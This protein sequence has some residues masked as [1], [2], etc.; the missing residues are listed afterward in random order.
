MN[1]ALILAILLSSTVAAGA[2]TS[3]GNTATIDPAK[4]QT[5]TTRVQK[6]FA[7]LIAELKKD[8]NE[9][10]V[11]VE[12]SSALNA[13]ASPGKKIVVNSALIDYL[14]DTALAFV[15]AH[16]LGHLERH[17][18]AK[19]IIEQSLVS[20]IKQKFF[21]TSGLYNGA[22]Y[23]GNLGFS[24]SQEK[25]ADLFAVKLIDKLYCDKPGKIDFFKQPEFRLEVKF[26]DYTHSLISKVGT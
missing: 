22:A 21:P 4:L 23:L 26:L 7:P 15:I 8:P 16:E 12:S 3:N 18:I 9:Y 24:R 25:D 10:S 14:N 19:S 13:H 1:K 6:I 5:Q 2:A 20:I 11:S 17:H